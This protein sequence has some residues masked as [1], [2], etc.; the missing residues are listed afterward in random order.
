[1]SKKTTIYIFVF[2]SNFG[3]KLLRYI[4]DNIEV[5]VNKGY[6]FKIAKLDKNEGRGHSKRL[7]KLGIDQ[8]PAMYHRGKVVVSASGVIA[9]LDRMRD[10]RATGSSSRDR[11]SA[12]MSKSTA[13][14]QNFMYREAYSGYNPETGKISNDS[15]DGMDDCLSKE[16]M[17]KLVAKETERRTARASKKKIRNA[18]IAPDESIAN[19]ELSVGRDDDDDDDNGESVARLLTEGDGDDRLL[20]EK[21]L[22]DN[23]D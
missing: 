20:A 17:Q 14:I 19:A 10:P 8:F 16:S 22:L 13:E 1:M 5:F 2:P 11:T 4:H 21:F 18:P 9:A 12:S 3:Y 7:A 6:H 15:M 23:I